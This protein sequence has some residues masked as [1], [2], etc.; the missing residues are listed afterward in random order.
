MKNSSQPKGDNNPPK[1][2]GMTI[3]SCSFAAVLNSSKIY[4][5]LSIMQLSD[6][7]WPPTKKLASW[8]LETKGI[9]AYNCHQLYGPREGTNHSVC[10]SGVQAESMSSFF[11]PATLCI[12]PWRSSHTWSARNAFWIKYL[13]LLSIG[14]VQWSFAYQSFHKSQRCT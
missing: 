3:E 14:L 5:I 12:D 1:Q 9:A 8:C 13:K 7:P 6:H 10:Y 11:Q 2:Q 4:K